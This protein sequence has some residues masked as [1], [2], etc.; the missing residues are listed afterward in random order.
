[1]R[2]DGPRVIYSSAD[3]VVVECS[4]ALDS[5]LTEIHHGAAVFIVHLHAGEPYLGRTAALR[6]RLSRLLRPRTV[7]SK[8]LNLRELAVRV[9][10]WPAGSS[11]ESTLVTLE[12][13]RALFPAKYTEVLK[14]R[15][16]AYVRVLSNTVFPRT[17]VTTRFGTGQHFGPFRTRAVADEFEKST[18]DLFQVRRC[19]E[20]FQPAP[21]HPGCI[22]GEMGMCLRPC[23]LGVTVEE[24]AS[25]VNRLNTFLQTG[26]KSALASAESARDKLSAEL[27][28][29]AA[30]REHKRTERIGE[31]LRLREELARDVDSLNGVAVLPS[32]LQDAAVLL[33]MQEGAWQPAVRFSAAGDQLVSLDKRVRE[34]AA[35][36]P[37]MEVSSRE[38]SE[39]IAILSRWFH[40]SWRD[41]VWIP[42]DSLDR[43]PYRRVV[44]AISKVVHTAAPVASH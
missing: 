12:L 28:F 43:L 44:S 29:E 6:R 24:Y 9:E 17:Q 21:D 7:P 25:E 18:L 39:H 38:R 13:A 35:S 16:P 40:S 32:H 22:Y 11:L 19:Q 41:G 31:V 20:D 8:L 33:F 34:A 37:K 36:L 30:A 42:F 5:T 2:V 27:N 15:M 1:M 3:P 4:D 14:L 26:G 10:Y 23:Q